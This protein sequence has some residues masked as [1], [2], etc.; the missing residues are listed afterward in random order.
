MSAKRQRL[1]DHREERLATIPV[2]AAVY[3]PAYG[4]SPVPSTS[5]VYIPPDTMHKLIMACVV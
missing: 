4:T 2:T 5:L 3:D 1:L